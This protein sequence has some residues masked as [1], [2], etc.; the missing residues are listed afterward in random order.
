[1]EKELLCSPE[2]RKINLCLCVWWGGGARFCC[3]CHHHLALTEIHKDIILSVNLYV[4]FFFFLESFQNRRQ[5][6]CKGVGFGIRQTWSSLDSATAW[7]S[8]PIQVTYPLWACFL[9]YSLERISHFIGYH[10]IKWAD[11]KKNMYNIVDSLSECSTFSIS[12]LFVNIESLL[13]V[14]IM[15]SPSL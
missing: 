7:L 13:S 8:D 5:Y 4:N 1:M 10:D 6:S 9:I 15:T 3:C 2:M 11:I 14:G 12:T